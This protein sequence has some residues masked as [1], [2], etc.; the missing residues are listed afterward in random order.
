MDDYDSTLTLDLDELLIEKE[1]L[2]S[3][4]HVFNAAEW[5]S[6]V[7]KFILLGEEEADDEVLTPAIDMCNCTSYTILH[8]TPFQT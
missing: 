6:L 5:L 7:D 3:G 4:E 1:I 2:E 8:D